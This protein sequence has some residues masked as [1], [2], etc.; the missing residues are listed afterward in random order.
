MRLKQDA[1]DCQARVQIWDQSA[2]FGNLSKVRAVFQINE[3][4]P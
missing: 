2:D 4:M 1:I 3:V